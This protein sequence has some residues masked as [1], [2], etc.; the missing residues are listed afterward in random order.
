MIM[1]IGSHHDDILYFDSV[2]ANKREELVLDKFKVTIGTIFNQEVLVV[3]QVITNQ[4]SSALTLYLIEKY[5]VI[6]VLVV[7]RCIAYTKDLKPL[8]I[9]LSKNVIAG[10]VD[11]INEDNVKFGQIPGF[12]QVFEG[13][14]DVITYLAS[15]FEKRT[16][17]VH[18]EANYIS[19]SVDYH[20][21]EQVKNLE[22]FSHVLGFENNVVFDNNSAGIAL[23]CTL[24]K[25]P[26]V[27]VKVVERHMD[28]M[29]DVNTYLKAIKEYVNIGKAIVTCI[30]DIGRNEIIGEQG[31]TV[32][33]SV[34]EK[35]IQLNY[36]SVS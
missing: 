9:C 11:Q 32:W 7:G 26:F 27:S 10:D 30:G 3:D 22:E 18:K 16:Y 14:K 34:K 12:E 29:S 2:L 17:S 1:I 20:N 15:A 8:E 6:L 5:F 33:L 31:D 36:S 24:S 21:K 25:V 19:T 28:Q 23:A 35:S 13:S 4:L